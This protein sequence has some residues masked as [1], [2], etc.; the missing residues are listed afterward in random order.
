MSEYRK[1]LGL[2]TLGLFLATVPSAVAATPSEDLSKTPA[3]VQETV[4]KAIGKHALAGVD[5]ETDG[6]KTVYEVDYKVG[7]ASY[8]VVVSEAG[9]ILEHEVTIDPSALP[10]AAVEA[11]HKAHADGKVGEIDIVAAGG[12]LY[13]EIDVKVGKETY[14]MKINADGS[15]LADAIDKD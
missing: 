4:K 8:A 9:E 11:A 2:V 5:K 3:A 1:M 13:Y 14:E 10:A 6:G 12:K 7:D 15:V